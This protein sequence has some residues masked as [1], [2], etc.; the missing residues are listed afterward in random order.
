LRAGCCLAAFL[1]LAAV[2]RPAAGDVDLRAQIST[3]RDSN[4]LEQLEEEPIEAAGFFRL[5]AEGILRPRSVPVFQRAAILLGGFTERYGRTSTEKRSQGETRIAADL[6]VGRQG[7]SARIEAGW[8]GRDYPDSTTRNFQRIWTRLR[9]VFRLG[10]H[11]WLIPRIDLWTLD[12]HQTQERDQVG[13]GVQM[14]YEMPLARGLVGHAGL[15]LGGVAYDRSS[16]QLA[17]E[18]Q[19][20]LQVEQGPSQSDNFRLIE[21]GARFFRH[22]LIQAQYGFRS[23]RSNSLGWSLRRHELRWLV[24]RSVGFGFTGQFYGSLESTHYTDAHLG[25]I[26][27]FRV[28]EE[29]EAADDNNLIALQLAHPL[30]RSWR[31][32]ARHA[33]FRN[34]SLLVGSYYRKRIW[35]AGLAWESEGFSAF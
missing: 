15:E 22:I 3:G 18:S 23:Q 26:F 13:Y 33:W 28:G 19:G 6:G 16:L 35:T 1:A 9:G 20:E 4:P 2:P 31:I 12:F 32:F 10:P 25:E 17:P 11:G 21:L 34:E 29:Q 30:G 24:S 14:A 7:G 5:Q 27:I 8:R